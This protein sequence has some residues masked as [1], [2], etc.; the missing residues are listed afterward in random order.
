[1]SVIFSSSKA[2]SKEKYRSQRVVYLMSVMFFLVLVL[3]RRVRTRIAAT[4]GTRTRPTRRSRRAS[5]GKRRAPRRTRAT[6][7]R[8]RRTKRNAAPRRITATRNARRRKVTAR[9]RR[10]T[11]SRSNR[12]RRIVTTRRRRR[13]G[14][15][16]E[17]RRRRFAGTPA[18]GVVGRRR[19]E[20][21]GSAPGYRHR[22]PTQATGNCGAV[23]SLRPRDLRNEVSTESIFRDTLTGNLIKTSNSET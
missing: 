9:G 7:A 17:V 4:R 22:P 21:A 19:R 14:A 6:P 1:M 16:S 11:R 18:G 20:V 23:Q 13:R 2:S 3:R 5:R 8:R 15:R 10:R 12:R